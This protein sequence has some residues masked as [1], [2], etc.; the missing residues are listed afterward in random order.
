MF[1]NRIRGAQLAKRVSYV[2]LIF[3]IILL[4]A[5]FALNGYSDRFIISGIFYIIM[6]IVVYF[7]STKYGENKNTWILLIICAI[8][9]IIATHGMLAI[10]FAILLLVSA[11]DMR[12]ELDN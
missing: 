4:V 7:L 6:F 12:K 10:A 1:E 8:I 9:T 3:A 5:G 11:N 2:Y